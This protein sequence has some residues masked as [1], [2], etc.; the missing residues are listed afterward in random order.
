MLD[1]GDPPVDVADDRGLVERGPDERVHLA[2]RVD[3]AHPVVAIR[4]D[5]QPGEDVDE[6]LGVVASV[7]GVAVRL[8]VRDVGER[9]AHRAVDGVGRQERLGVHR[10]HVVDAVEIGRLEAASAHRPHDD[11]EENGATKA[12]DVDGPRGGLRVV[13]DLRA[14]D[15][16]RKLI[17]PVHGLS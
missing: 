15:A 5:A 4:T 11:V 9:P 8:L 16:G 17:G 3:V 12:A 14:G 6:D 10:V 7:R 1:V 13:D 2:G